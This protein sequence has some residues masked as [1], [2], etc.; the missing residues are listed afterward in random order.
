MDVSSHFEQ[1]SIVQKAGSAAI[2]RTGLYYTQMGKKWMSV[3]RSSNASQI[4][5]V[6]AFFVPAP[7]RHRHV[8]QQ[9]Y[10]AWGCLWQEKRGPKF[11]AYTLG[12]DE[13]HLDPCRRRVRDPLSKSHLGCLQN[14]QNT[15]RRA[16]HVLDEAELRWDPY[17]HREKPTVKHGARKALA[18]TCSA[19][20][21]AYDATRSP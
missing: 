11:V 21:R 17:P 1:G 13:L 4:H 9:C 2:E 6:L 10:L 3:P 14:G 19:S 8:K 18:M 12:E 15:G 16:E 7:S 5:T 20:E